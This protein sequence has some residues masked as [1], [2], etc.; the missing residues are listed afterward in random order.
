LPTKTGIL[1]AA[2]KSRVPFT[3]P[4]AGS[5]LSVGIA[6]ARFEKKIQF[7]FDIT[8]DTMEMMTIAQKTRNSGII[9]LGSVCSQSMVKYGGDFFVYYPLDSARS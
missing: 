3:V 1:T 8:Q 7:S 5:P 9:T 6:R 4:I 2:F